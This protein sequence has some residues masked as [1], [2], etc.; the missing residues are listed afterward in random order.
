MTTNCITKL[1]NALVRPGRIDHQVHFALATHEQIRE[2]FER[3][4]DSTDSSTECTSETSH[5]EIYKRLVKCDNVAFNLG[6]YMPLAIVQ[7]RKINELTKLF[8]QTFSEGVFSPAEI[9]GYL[10]RWKAD[11]EGAL[12]GAKAWNNT[13]LE[14]KRAVVA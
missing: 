3:M 9:Q 12:R 13:Q 5:A 10:L 14:A 1:D 2:I 4:Y 7:H 11:P 6:A 8:T